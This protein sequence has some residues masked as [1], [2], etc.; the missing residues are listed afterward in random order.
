MS[1]GS[2][3]QWFEELFGFAEGRNFA[4]NQKEFV[5]EGEE[6]VCAKSTV[7]PRQFVGPW[8]TPSLQELRE[9]IAKLPPASGAGG[10]TFTHLPTPTGVVD[11]ILDPE[12]RDAVFQA[13]SQFNALEM[14][15]PEVTPRHGIAIYAG[16]PTQGP[17][18]A[19]SCPAGT[20]FRNY[21][22]DVDGLKGQGEKQIDTLDGVGA[23]VGNQ[24]GKYWNMR[25]APPRAHAQHARRALAAL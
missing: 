24:D 1:W 7:A 14:I 4:A 9:R 19:L 25:S 2:G 18:C 17:K 12:N 23:V 13:A 16:D 3:N 5:M 22:V 21:L 8:E 11:L 20:V 6:L 15:S 10:L